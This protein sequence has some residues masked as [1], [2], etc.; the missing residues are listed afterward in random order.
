[1]SD[2]PTS[3]KTS[4]ATPVIASVLSVLS[5]LVACGGAAPAA[6]VEA[7]AS[8][9]GAT[10]ARGCKDAADCGGSNLHCTGGRCVANHAG[11]PCPSP[12]DCGPG[13]SC[14]AGT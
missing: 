11:C 9:C 2:P 7:T 13:S 5:V 6:P 3:Q 10:G 8:E 12:T 4:T 1:M 14:V